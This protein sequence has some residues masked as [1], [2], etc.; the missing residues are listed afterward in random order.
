MLASGWIWTKGPLSEGSGWS[1][2]PAA[3]AAA[4]PVYSLDGDT[5]G[6]GYRITKADLAKAGLLILVRMG[7][8]LKTIP[9]KAE[10]IAIE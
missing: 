1:S 4:R 8:E 3:S 6:C 5:F 10:N 9:F 7:G 2:P